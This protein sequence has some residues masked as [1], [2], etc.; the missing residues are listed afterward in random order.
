MN[1]KAT[2]FKLDIGADVT[3]ISSNTCVIKQSPGDNMG[4]QKVFELHIL[5][6]MFRIET[7]KPLAPLLGTNNLSSL[8][9]RV[10]RFRLH[11]SYFEYQI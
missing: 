2:Q 6:K 4:L 8:P 5:G 11:L 9:P 10:L 3:A 1:D 7:D